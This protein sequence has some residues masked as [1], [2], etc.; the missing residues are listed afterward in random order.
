MLDKIYTW[1]NLIFFLCRV[2]ANPAAAPKI[3]FASYKSKIPIAGLVDS[4]QKQYE[5]MKVPYPADK[6]TT[7]VNNQEK[8]A[9]RAYENYFL[10][11]NNGCVV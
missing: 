2:L 4:L 7:E 9:V 5:A 11:Y 3:D 1:F 10:N 8:T 6:L